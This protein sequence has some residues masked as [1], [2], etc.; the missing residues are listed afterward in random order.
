LT[1]LYSDLYTA[2]G[3]RQPLGQPRPRGSTPLQHLR[4]AH[5]QG[6]LLGRSGLAAAR[7][8]DAYRGKGELKHGSN[9]IQGLC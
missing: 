6:P 7:H 5:R 8:H 9:R 4:G 1:F 2:T 3:G